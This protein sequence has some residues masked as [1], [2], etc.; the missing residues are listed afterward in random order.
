MDP[1]EVLGV[2][3]DA[4]PEDIRKAYR[5]LAVQHHPDKGGDQEKFKQISA[6]YEV[7]S[8][9]QKRSNFDQF[10]TADGPQMP[11]MGEMFRNFFGQA[12]GGPPRRQ[13]RQYIISISLEEAFQGVTKK[14]KLS[15]DH[16]CYS[17][18]QNCQVCNGKGGIPIQMG[19]FMMNKPCDK[20]QGAGVESKGCPACDN[21]K[22]KSDSEVVTINIGKCVMDGETFVIPNKGE[23]PVK[24]GE[25]A[26]NL[27]VQVRVRPHAVFVRE[28]NHL[29]WTTKISFDESVKG[30]KVTI[31]HFSGEMNIDTSYFGII[32]P[33]IRYEIKGKGMNSESNLYI[34]F[35]IQ[36]PK[37]A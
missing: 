20:C 34:V 16:P 35:D 32:D 3:R 10:G 26:G 29:V 13:D 24:Q 22:V 36:Y 5:K 27:V 4:S 31:P 23:Q 33:R 12:A 18:Q 14:L 11:D 7:L 15:I 21:K 25:M 37:R 19:P 2:T 1:Y 9:E 28:G 8:D 30:T 17:C 6:A